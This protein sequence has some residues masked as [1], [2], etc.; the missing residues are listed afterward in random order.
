MLL[1]SRLKQS[2]PSILTAAGLCPS[3]IRAQDPPLCADE[4]GDAAEMGASDNGLNLLLPNCE[5]WIRGFEAL[6]GGDPQKN[7]GDEAAWAFDLSMLQLPYHNDESEFNTISHQTYE[8]N[9]RKQ[10]FERIQNLWIQVSSRNKLSLLTKTK[11]NEKYPQRYKN[12]ESYVLS[13]STGLHTYK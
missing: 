7:G 5:S 9:K 12:L 3:F 1:R 13:C 10:W 11:D 4:D 8:L 6:F 2:N